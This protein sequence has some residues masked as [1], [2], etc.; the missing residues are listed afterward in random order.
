[1]EWDKQRIWIYLLCTFFALTFFT[2][3]TGFFIHSVRN[4]RLDWI[5]KEGEREMNA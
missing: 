2:V 1:M 4:Y 5:K 3:E